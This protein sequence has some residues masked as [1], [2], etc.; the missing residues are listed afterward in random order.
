[1][2][3]SGLN[4]RIILYLMY[5]RHIAQNKAVALKPDRVWP[6]LCVYTIMKGISV[7][8]FQGSKL[9]P[10]ALGHKGTAYQ[11]MFCVCPNYACHLKGFPSSLLFP[12]T[13][14]VSHFRDTWP[15]MPLGRFERENTHNQSFC[16]D[17]HA[18]LKWWKS[19]WTYRLLRWNINE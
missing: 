5:L 17:L 9:N 3:T 15:L 18:F 7:S 14:L 10:W 12:V 2:S 13:N 1:M 8:N 19:N 4:M 11:S 16:W 6:R